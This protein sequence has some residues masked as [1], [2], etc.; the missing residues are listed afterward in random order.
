M[1]CFVS[2]LF[3]KI[4]TTV[5]IS[6]LITIAVL[7]VLFGSLW[8]SQYVINYKRIRLCGLKI[9]RA[10]S[11]TLKYTYVFR[12]ERSEYGLTVETLLKQKPSEKLIIP[13]GVAAI[14][15]NAFRKCSAGAVLLPE[16]LRYI[17]EFAFGDCGFT[18]LTIP[19]AVEYIGANAFI[20]CD[21]LEFVEMPFVPKCSVSAFNHCRKL[22]TVIIGGKI[23][24]LSEYGGDGLTFLFYFIAA[25]E[26]AVDG[27]TSGISYIN[28]NIIEMFDFFI[29]QGSVEFIEK[30]LALPLDI[31]A[32]ALDDVINRAIESSQHEIYVMLVEYK[33]NNLKFEES[34]AERFAL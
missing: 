15:K 17:G 7:V 21:K 20:G 28:E 32:E 31:S 34:T 1:V 33:R 2:A 16:S 18:E 19:N 11:V 24:E 23:R 22:R 26:C 12:F 27:D 29:S 8:V 14:D 13:E 10:L 4:Q 9:F 5:G 25:I 3:E 6:A 30:L